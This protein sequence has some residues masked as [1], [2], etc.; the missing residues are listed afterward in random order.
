MRRIKVAQIGTS[1]YSHGYSI[2]KSII[3][4]PEIFDVVRLCSSRKRG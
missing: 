2:F 3:N 1:D 4:Q